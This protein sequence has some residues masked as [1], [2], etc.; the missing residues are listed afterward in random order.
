M[1]DVMGSFGLVE[2]INGTRHRDLN[3]LG[4]RLAQILGEPG[5][6]AT[7]GS[8][9]HTSRVGVAYTRT[10]GVRGEDVLASLIAGRCEPAGQHGSHAALDDDTHALLEANAGRR[11][12]LFFAVADD[13]MRD[14]PQLARELF[15]AVLGGTIAYAVVT[16]FGRQ[17]ALARRVA[18]LFEAELAEADHHDQALAAPTERR[19]LHRHLRRD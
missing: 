11:A 7:G 3:T 16:E 8:D 9:S 2:A 10:F 15:A 1:R 12:G 14:V 4:W 5:V 19:P 13:F 17:R 18:E 6:A